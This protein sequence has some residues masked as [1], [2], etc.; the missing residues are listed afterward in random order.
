MSV[1]LVTPFLIRAAVAALSLGLVASCS[2][3]GSG[4][5]SPASSAAGAPPSSAPA[6]P[7][8]SLAGCDTDPW[9]SAPVTVSHP[10]PVPPVPVVTAIRAATHSAC[11]YDR[12]VLDVSGQLPGYT[13]RYADRVVADPSGKVLTVPGSRFLL[14]TLRPTQ[15]HR[16]SGQSTL[17]TAPVH[18]GMPVLAGY[19]LAGDFEGVVTVAIGLTSAAGIRVGEL[20]GHLF[21]DFRR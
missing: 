7:S 10:V 1:K 6:S 16:A 14:I 12:M 20:P 19:T 17:S 21:I 11:G 4:P 2:Q 8:A 3:A 18:L 15:A 13:I 5:A 9:Q